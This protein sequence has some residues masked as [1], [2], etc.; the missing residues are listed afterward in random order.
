MK[1]QKKLHFA[2]VGCGHISAKHADAI[3]AID[4]CELVAVCDAAVA[5]MQAFAETYG[6]TKMY[7]DYEQLVKDP[8]IDVICICTPSW[9]HAKMTIA[10]AKHDKHV[11][12]EKP[13]AMTTEEAKTVLAAFA[14]SKGK[15]SVVLQNRFTP[16]VAF[17]KQMSGML[18]KLQYVSADM[19]WYRDAKYYESEWRGKVELDGGTLLN[20]GTHFVDAIAYLSGKDFA[21]VSAYAATVGHAIEAEDVITVNFGF[22]DGTIGNI[23]GNTIS[24]P[25]NFEGTITLFYEKATVRLGGSVFNEITYWKG[26]GEEEAKELQK[27]LVAEDQRG[28]HK[29]VILNMVQYLRDGKPLA[30]SGEEGYKSVAMIEKA[31]ESARTGKEVH[32]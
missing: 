14:R 24:Y 25:Q 3:Q 15:I 11:I 13:L 22:N 20:Q 19:F 18:G 30:V 4:D 6:V 2:I 9:L 26:E 21:K 28:T 10:A 16:A 23:Q 1:E 31:Y 5:P 29:D 32:V 27:R 12:V 17:V 7:T 8:D